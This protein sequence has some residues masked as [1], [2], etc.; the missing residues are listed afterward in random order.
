MKDFLAQVGGAMHWV[1][2]GVNLITKN[3]WTVPH[4]VYLMFEL[5]EPFQ[6]DSGQIVCARTLP[7][8]GPFVCVFCFRHVISMSVISQDKGNPSHREHIQC[9]ND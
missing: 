8:A 9:K 2:L 1:I 7:I 3:I 5:V 4:E 6:F